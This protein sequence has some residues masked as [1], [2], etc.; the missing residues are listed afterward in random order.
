MEF[1]ELWDEKSE[2]MVSDLLRESPVYVRYVSSGYPS[3][4]MI[5]TMVDACWRELIFR[6]TIRRRKLGLFLRH[7]VGKKYRNGWLN[8]V[9]KSMVDQ[10]LIQSAS[11]DIIRRRVLVHSKN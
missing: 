3:P 11:S 5:G 4:E 7:R 2:K 10:G 8:L 6:G 1:Y 9:L